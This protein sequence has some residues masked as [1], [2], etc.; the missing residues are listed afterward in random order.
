M[1]IEHVLSYFSQLLYLVIL[2]KCFI[3]KLRMEIKFLTN[4]THMAKIRILFNGNRIVQFP[5]VVPNNTRNKK[6][7]RALK[8][9]MEDE[10]FSRLPG[11]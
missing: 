1:M 11:E 4:G 2:G 8:I 9:L 6:E 7:L 3:T 5:M 10:V